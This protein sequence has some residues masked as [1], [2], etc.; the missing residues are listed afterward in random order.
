MAVINVFSKDDFLRFAD[1]LPARAYT[2][3]TD[4]ATYVWLVPVVTSNHR[5]YV[6]LDIE[7]EAVWDEVK[8]KLRERGF[9]IIRGHVSFPKS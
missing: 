6:R 7:D 4:E 1:V 9:T 2:V 3:V 5:H 8:R